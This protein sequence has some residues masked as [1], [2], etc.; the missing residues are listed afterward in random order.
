MTNLTLSCGA[1][2]G[3][4]RAPAS[5]SQAHRLLIAAALGKEPT[6][7]ICDNISKDIIA[8]I[9]CL[10]ALCADIFVAD[11]MIHIVPRRKSGRRELYC[12]ESGTTLR[13]LLPLCGALGEEAIFHLEG[14]LPNR[15]LA[16][17][18]HIL[19]EHG[20]QIEAR[21]EKLYC[22][23]RLQCGNF[24]ID[25]DVSSQFISGLL[26]A[27][28][29][30]AGESSL[31]I[32]KEIQSA[33]YIAM[34]EETLQH[35]GIQFL[36]S[37]N[38]Y[39]ISGSQHYLPPQRCIVEGD[40]S[41]AAFFL[42]MGALSE[43]GI[44]VTNLPPVTSQGDREVVEIL[45]RFGANVT[46][47]DCEVYVKTGHLHGCQIDAG[48]IPDVIPPL[49][50]VAACAKG[51]TRIIN[52]ERLRLKESDRLHAIAQMLISLGGRVTEL[53]DSLEIE[54][55]RLLGGSANSYGDHRIAMSAAVA[56]CACREAVTLSDPDCVNKSF[57]QF[58]ELF[59]R[60]EGER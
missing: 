6:S 25:G 13:L 12:G 49:A 15:P 20:M 8:T 40:Y 51:T 35:S 29:L 55:S 59:L 31:H 60:L 56:V 38:D 10:D 52:A 24:E 44:R 58:W 18:V 21:G 54:G 41:A 1:R 26:F 47:A 30:L 17:F 16:P 2:Y 27:L 57:P 9:R 48:Q 45:R 50:V 23:G 7:V 43:R 14:R 28:P 19:C 22:S 11:R 37:G 36:R 42:C 3:S 39:T 32:K 46:V 34:T 53:P 33:P 4:L 5:K